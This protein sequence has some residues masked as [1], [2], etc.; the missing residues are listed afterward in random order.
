MRYWRARHIMKSDQSIYTNNLSLHCHDLGADRGDVPIFR[1][2]NLHLQ[3]G[4]VLQIFGGNGT[5]KSTLLTILAG[6]LS[7]TI[8][9]ASWKSG[10]TS[11]LVQQVRNQLSFLG[12]KL[13]MK[14]ALTAT[15]NLQFWA[16]MAGLTVAQSAKAGFPIIEKVLAAMEV[17]DLAQQKISHMSAGQQKRIALARVLMLN[18]P[19]WLLDE[20]TA[21]LDAAGQL[22]VLRL[23]E[24]HVKKGGMV[25]IATHHPLDV[26]STRIRLERAER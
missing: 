10:E 19:V 21:N 2:M 13:A 6:L 26:F 22:L 4:E 18:K 3:A 23:I 11:L 8:G 20:P 12:H 14:S 16:D 1:D 17:A 5:G 15:E 9:R 24:A 7:P 25:I